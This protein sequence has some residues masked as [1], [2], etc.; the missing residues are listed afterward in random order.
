MNPSN[1]LAIVFDFDD[2]L[3]PDSTSLL[4]RSR[5]VDTETFWR[6]EAK[7]LVASGYDPTHAYLRRILDRVQPGGE[8]EG[9]S[10]R[11]LREFGR[12]LDD[13]FFVGLPELFDELKETARRAFRDAQVEYYIIS[14]GLQEVL[15]GSRIVQGH[16]DAVY[17]CELGSE[18]DDEGKPVRYIKR[19]VTFSEKTRYIFEINKG[20][21]PEDAR[22][23]PYLVNKAVAED[24]RRVPIENMIYVGDGLTDVPCF[25][26]V[27]KSGGTAIGVFDPTKEES[28]KR[29]F[30]E[31]AAPK[32]VIGTYAPRYREGDDMGAFLR[33]AVATRASEILLRRKEAIR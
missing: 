15:D 8:L 27:D 2:T 5:G 7:A 32:R 16:F 22:D 31:F 4:L 24:Q 14:G 23:R 29:A 10:N 19:A 21:R 33:A 13:Q 17:A 6:E 28:A 18:D 30:Q 12:T 3:V 20:I 9:L 25:S 26:L 11:E 1:I